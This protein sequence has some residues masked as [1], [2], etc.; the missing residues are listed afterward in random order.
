MDRLDAMQAFVAVADLQGFAPAAAQARPVAIGRHAAD[1]GAGRTPG[2]AAVT[3]YHA[4]GNADRCRRTL[5]GAGPPH[6]RRCRGS[7]R[8]GRGRAHAAGW[9]AGGIRAARVRPAAR[10]SRDVGLSEA[11]SRGQPRNCGCRTASSIWWKTASIW[12][13]GSVTSRIRRSSRVTSARCGG[14]WSRR[15][16]ISKPMANRST[17]RKSPPTKRSSLAP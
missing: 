5:S 16:I 9:T 7:R 13:C 12:R 14:S 3:A 2:R 11:L 6:P 15:R 10:Q 4:V 1:R 8:L 17:R